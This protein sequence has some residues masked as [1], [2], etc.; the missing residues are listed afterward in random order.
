MLLKK[1][2]YIKYCYFQPPKT[3]KLILV[4]N[5]DLSSKEIETVK[6]PSTAFNLLDRL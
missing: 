6:V 1:L 3:I 4:P 2:K 5:G